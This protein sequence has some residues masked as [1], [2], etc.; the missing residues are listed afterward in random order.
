MNKQTKTSATLGRE[1]ILKVIQ[2]LKNMVKRIRRRLFQKSKP[3]VRYGNKS[4][5][6]VEKVMADCEST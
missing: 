3:A 6:T 5:Q 4:Y 1:S 2:R